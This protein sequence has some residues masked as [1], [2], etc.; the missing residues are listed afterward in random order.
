MAD[1]STSSVNHQAMNKMNLQF[2]MEV[3]GQVIDAVNLS[4]IQLKGGNYLTTVRT[5]LMKKHQDLIS[6]SKS[7]PQFYL[8]GVPSQINFFSS[9]KASLPGNAPDKE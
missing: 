3:D 9:L 8:T 7:P 4:S 6:K 2:V 5:G 1:S